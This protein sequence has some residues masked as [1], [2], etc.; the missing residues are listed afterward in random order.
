MSTDCLGSFDVFAGQVQETDAL[1]VELE[2][3]VEGLQSYLEEV[4]GRAQSQRER[5]EDLL[6]ERG[7]LMSRLQQVEDHR[8]TAQKQA[9]EITLLR[10]VRCM[11][12]HGACVKSIICRM[13]AL[14][15]WSICNYEENMKMCLFC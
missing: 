10:E 7:E 9:H 15:D 13:L 6:R 14:C 5:C 1:R 4:Q 12:M 2:G 11:A 3:V 8:D